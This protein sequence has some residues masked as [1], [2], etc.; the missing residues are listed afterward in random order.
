MFQRQIVLNKNHSFFL[1]GARNT[2]KST[3]V[4]DIFDQDS[5]LFINLLDY[6]QYQRFAST[7]N[8]LYDI[9]TSLPPKV[10]HI[11]IDEVQKLPALLDVVHRLI[12]ETDKVFVLTGS[13]ARKLKYGGANL[14]AGRAF[15]YALFPF[16]HIELGQQFNLEQALN[17]GT[18]PDI[19]KLSS[20]QD[21]KQFLLSYANTYLKEE[22]AGE[23]LVR[24]LDPFRRFLDV[25]AQSNGQILN[26][27][28][29]ARDTGV[30]DKTIKSY[31]SILEDTLVGFFLESYHG[32]F[33]KRLNLSPKF[34]FFDTGIARALTGMIDLPLRPGTNQYGYAFEHF[35]ILECHRL[36]AYFK[37]T[38]KFSYLKTKEDAEVDLIIE[39]PGLAILLIEIKSTAQVDERIL[40]PFIKLS[41]EIDN[42]EAIC[43]SNDPFARQ[44][45]PV[46]AMPWRQ[47][48]ASIFMT[49]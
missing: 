6:D 44:I 1:F 34:Y 11:I 32:S 21:K 13:S 23:Q 18:L 37:Q 45:G 20:D 19:F 4:A 41:Q 39:R 30:S 25:A 15:V 7:P 31:Y 35:I 49:D 33:R 47:G 5:S 48:L 42:S 38:Y 26:F 28:K 36:A 24:D 12:F 14:L 10:T 43:L 29:I 3:L 40:K 8:V 16:T 9:V 22:V 27:S 2:G 17:Y 46:K